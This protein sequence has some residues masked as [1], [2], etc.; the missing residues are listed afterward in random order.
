MSAPW[1]ERR[2]LRPRCIRFAAGRLWVI[3]ETQPVAAL[4]EPTSGQIDRIVS[5]PEIPSPSPALTLAS[6]A[7]R[8]WLQ[9]RGTDVLACVTVD[10]VHHAEYLEGT[11]LLTA[12]S[13]GAWC[14]RPTRTRD[15][16]ARTAD[17]PPLPRPQ[18]RPPLLLAHPGGGTS[19]IDVDGV[20]VAANFDEQSVHLGV[21][22]TPWSRTYRGTPTPAEYVLQQ[23]KS[24]IHLPLDASATRIELDDYPRSQADG[25][26]HTT[27][28]ADITYTSCTA[29]SARSATA[30]D[31]T[32]A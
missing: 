27:E 31:G 11:H 1:S 13:S 3:D 6:H 19:P 21:E 4:L 24:W 5:W 23:S 20:L 16:V 14:F 25:A 2:L 17:E 29:A 12:G 10:G 22:H 28:Y 9:Y 30:S 26:W 8:V 18:S 32:G 7:D 15:D